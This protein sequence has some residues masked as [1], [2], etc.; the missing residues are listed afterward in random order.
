MKFLVFTKGKH[1]VNKECV[2]DIWIDLEHRCGFC[3]IDC[4]KRVQLGITSGAGKKCN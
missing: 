4:N 1:I 2:G 3:G